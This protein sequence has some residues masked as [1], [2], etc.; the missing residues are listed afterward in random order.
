MPGRSKQIQCA[1]LAWLGSPACLQ[2]LSSPLQPSCFSLPGRLLHAHSF[3]LLTHTAPCLPHPSFL[4]PCTPHLFPPS[5]H[6]G[7]RD[8]SSHKAAN[9]TW[10]ASLGE[11]KWDSHPAGMGHGACGHQENP[12]PQSCCFAALF[13]F[14]VLAAGRAP[15]QPFHTNTPGINSGAQLH[16]LQRSPRKSSGSPNCLPRG[17]AA[18][19][20]LNIPSHCLHI[21]PRAGDRASISHAARTA[22]MPA[23]STQTPAVLPKP[24]TPPT[25]QQQSRPRQSLWQE[26]R[27]SSSL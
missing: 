18:Q 10:E 25:A 22:A 17:S 15:E 9:C 13:S 21:L 16:Q 19:S 26:I 2:S 5:R 11:Q 14:A 6:P 12:A 4:H 7:P 1:L 24:R 8:G 27:S 20:Q 3:S 23:T